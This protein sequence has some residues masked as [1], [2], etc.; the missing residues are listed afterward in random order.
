MNIQ[1]KS[2]LK[3]LVFNDRFDKSSIFKLTCDFDKS[4]NSK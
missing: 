4:F 3:I 1:I 2:K